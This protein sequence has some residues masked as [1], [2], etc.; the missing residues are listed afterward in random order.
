MAHILKF[1]RNPERNDKF[2]LWLSEWR[3]RRF[4]S[5]AGGY[6][7]DLVAGQKAICLCSMCQPRFGERANRYRRAARPPFNRGVI[8]DCDACRSPQEQCVMYLPEG[9]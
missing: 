4:G 9:Y 5:V 8:A 2:R 6:I 3:G 1:G 7:A